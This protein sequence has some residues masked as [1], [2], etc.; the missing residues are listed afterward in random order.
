MKDKAV[1]T[2]VG[3]VNHYPQGNKL[4]SDDPFG[5]IVQIGHCDYCHLL[6][7]D[8]DSNRLECPTCHRESDYRRLDPT[9]PTGFMVDYH[10]KACSFDGNFERSPRASRPR[11]AAAIDIT[12]R[13]QVGRARIWARLPQKI[14]LD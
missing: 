4:E 14:F 7:Q 11:M 8:P 3:L 1:Y 2:A 12:E 13:Q 6:H 5:Q 10:S 9:E